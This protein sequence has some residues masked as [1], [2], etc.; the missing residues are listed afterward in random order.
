MAATNSCTAP[1][2][3]K[4]KRNVTSP[5]DRP[6]A[7]PVTQ[8]ARIDAIDVLRGIALLG[9]LVMNIQM[10]AM[11]QAT[12]FN[13]TAYGDLEGTNRYVWLAG[14]G[15]RRRPTGALP[16]DGVAAGH[17]TAPRPPSLVR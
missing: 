4:G 11:P 16:P 12:Y 6:D 13:P 5:A 2:R 10:F 15:A 3:R 1:A 14:R 8:T 9:I 7:G 17:R